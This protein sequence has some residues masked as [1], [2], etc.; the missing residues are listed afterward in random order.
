MFKGFRNALTFISFFLIVSCQC[1]DKG[2]KANY[3]LEQKKF[4]GA[5]SIGDG[6][7][8]LEISDE[9]RHKFKGEFE[10][11]ASEGTYEINILNPFGE[12]LLT[13]QRKGNKLSL[14]NNPLKKVNLR[15]NDKGFLLFDD[16]W[17]GLRT[18]EIPCFL[19]GKIPAKWLDNKESYVMSPKKDKFY[20]EEEDRRI[21]LSFSEDKVCL[22]IHWN[23]F[24][25]FRRTSVKICYFKDPLLGNT[26]L[27]DEKFLLKTKKLD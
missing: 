8:V 14:K 26:F 7:G 2:E 9:G 15:V 13:L 10:W 19:K 5:C 16:H 24:W 17:V 23:V 22:D 20:L 11:L 3:S 18:D 4:F 27:F 12:S 21:F 1:F 6:Y 25:I